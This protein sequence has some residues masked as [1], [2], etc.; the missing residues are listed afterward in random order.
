[1]Q[2]LL[3][4]AFSVLAVA[5]AALPCAAQQ[6]AATEDIK[7][8]RPQDVLERSV[9]HFPSILESLAQRS[10]AAG[11]NL[12]A[13]GA[14]DI[15]FSASSRNRITGF[16][17]GQIIE[18][19]A[20]RNLRPFG[21][22]VF[23]SYRL[24]DGNF[25]VYEDINFTDSLG[26]VKIGALFS[27]LRNRNIDSRRFSI[28]DTSLALKQADLDI[29]LTKL[30]VQHQALSAYW[31]WVAAGH[32]LQI[33]RDLRVLAEERQK[34]LQ[35]QVDSGARAAIFLTENQQNIT[36]RRIFERQAERDLNA[37]IARL[38]LFYRGP[39]GAIVSPKLDMLPPIPVMDGVVTG[40][41]VETDP[42]L[43][44][45]LSLRPDLAVLR[46]GVERARGRVALAEND[47]KPRLDFSFEASKD[48]GNVAEG[49]ISREETDTVVG[50]Q[51]S[52][53]LEMR[54]ARGRLASAK[55]SMDA[56]S[57]QARLMEDR[58]AVEVETILIEL[59]TASD[60]LELAALEVSQADTMRNAE[61]RR[62]AQGAS[63][64]F[65]VN[66][67][68]ETAADARVRYI[69][70]ELRGHLSRADFDAA[71]IDTKALGIDK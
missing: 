49:G 36:R 5:S 29:L 34:G 55:A 68:E 62:F 54:Q 61:Q 57:Q 16:W 51:F 58:I 8:L 41:L 30:G 24:S 13:Q 46:T 50:L 53:P 67:R 42:A 6:I 2:Q 47:L 65:L 15:V 28:N 22:Q 66:V 32:K 69:D 23:G 37:A 14:F 71:V 33:F 26:E 31:R 60:V 59:R 12:E 19:K 70:A 48:L 20:Q 21:G 3:R 40:W 45:V 11:R 44:A 17:D 39:D 63:D 43:P 38:A 9:R 1:M 25:P 18:G 35:K 7:I 4:L 52:V 27:L 64:F 10:V 56:I